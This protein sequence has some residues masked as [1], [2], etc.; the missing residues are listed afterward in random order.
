M[1]DG[2]GS[3]LM[4]GADGSGF[5]FVEGAIGSFLEGLLSAGRGDRRLGCQAG[6]NRYKRSIKPRGSRGTVASLRIGRGGGGRGR[7]GEAGGRG[8]GDEEAG[9]GGFTFQFI[10]CHQ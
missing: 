4:R 2:R 1:V 9:W 3:W 10:R 5:W 6:V 8:E 7:E